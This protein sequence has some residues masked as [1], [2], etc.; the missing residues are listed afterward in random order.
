MSV[1]DEALRDL[2][3]RLRASTRPAPAPGRPCEQGTDLDH[4]RALTGHRAD[5]F[6]CLPEGELQRTWYERLNGSTRF[7]QWC[8]APRSGRFAA[9]EHPGTPTAGI[10][11]HFTG[12]GRA[13]GPPG[14]QPRPPATAR[15]ARRSPPSP[16]P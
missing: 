8:V 15:T 9:L 7:A 11:D 3:A 14:V 5:R 12:R 13:Q 10:R 16:A 1:P 6:A 4:L 2:R